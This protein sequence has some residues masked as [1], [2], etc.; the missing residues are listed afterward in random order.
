[1]NEQ[2]VFWSSDIGE[3]YRIDN[4][5][6]ASDIGVAAWDEM[7]SKIGK[8][9]LQS[10][11]ECGSNIGRNV[12]LLH[13]LIPSAT[14]NVVEINSESLQICRDRW[15]ISSY[16][17]G[18]ISTA[19]FSQKFDLVFSCGVLIHVNPEDLVA[20]MKSMFE[21]SSRYVLIAEYFN[22]EPV[23]ITY[24]GAEQKLFKR[25]FGKLFLEN[26]NANLVD[27][28]FLWSY[29]YEQGGFDDVTFWLFEKN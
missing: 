15:N 27:C 28:G 5:G 7:L 13:S 18:S 8:G 22:R 14:A 20:S 25:D 1:M 29:I 4:D 19:Q 21:L 11:L 6:F 3:V 2:E 26:F 23:S 10:Y 9:D 17:L 12:G 16:Y 24:R